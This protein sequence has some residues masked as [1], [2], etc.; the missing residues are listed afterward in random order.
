MKNCDRLRT[1]CTGPFMDATCIFEGLSVLTDED[2]EMKS[3]NSN[4][5][6]NSGDNNN[7]YDILLIIM[8]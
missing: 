1:Y 7:R 2:G 5:V 3:A 8:L 4:C 6:D